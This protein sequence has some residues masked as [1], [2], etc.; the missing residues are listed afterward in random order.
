MNYEAHRSVPTNYL[1]VQPNHNLIFS[2]HIHSSIELF[3]L[4]AGTI[5]CA[6]AGKNYS[7]CAGQALLILPYETHSYSEPQNA[8]GVT[9]IFST[10]FVP[11]FAAEIRS[12]QLSS[13][14]F[15]PSP[16][17]L[18]IDPKKD[19]RISQ[20]GKLYLLC[21]E[22]VS[23]NGLCPCTSKNNLLTRKILDYIDDHFTDE[24]SLGDMAKELGYSYNYLSNFINKSFGCSF[25]DIVNDSRIN[26]A[27]I[28]LL[29]TD[30][31][32]AGISEACGFGTIRSFN[33]SFK[34][35][36]GLTPKEFLSIRFF[37]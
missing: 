7:L 26:R 3:C 21:A 35:S 19:S 18:E 2:D 1:S 30:S 10:D 32:I 34:K 4:K 37:E 13:P 29:N 36:L 20:I 23:Q 8:D 6:V 11:E 5:R 16:Y 22:A 15:T 17:L 27:I 24:I 12:A 25:S 9:V 33:R 28:A 31:S 14:V